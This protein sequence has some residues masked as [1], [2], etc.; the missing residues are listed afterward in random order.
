MIM[1]KED[2]FSIKKDGNFYRVYRKR[3]RIGKFLLL[4]DAEKYFEKLIIQEQKAITGVFIG[5]DIPEALEVKWDSIMPALG[6]MYKTISYEG[7]KIHLINGEADLKFISDLL[8]AYN[9][10]LKIN[11]T[12]DVF[13]VDKSLI[14][15]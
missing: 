11:L 3:T 10:L 4:S 8:M 5:Y 1:K 12:L 14:E 6:K 15:A 13:K 9:T 7:D 2:I